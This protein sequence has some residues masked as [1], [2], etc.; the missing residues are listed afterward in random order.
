MALGRK[1]FGMAIEISG[2]GTTQVP[3]KSWTTPPAE[4]P[5]PAASRTA[6]MTR[7]A[8]AA[9]AAA[10]NASPNPALRLLTSILK[11]VLLKSM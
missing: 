2:A 11:S 8:A 1:Q 3:P 10:A 5:A 6:Q 9:P 4:S 7:G